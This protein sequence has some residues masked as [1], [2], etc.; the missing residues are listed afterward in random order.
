LDAAGQTLAERTYFSIGGGFV[1]DED[2]MGRNGPAPMG[3]DPLPFESGADLLARP[4][5]PA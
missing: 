5:T 1:R 2:E 4:P 3:P